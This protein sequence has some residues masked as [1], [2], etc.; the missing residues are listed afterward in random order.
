[1]DFA[2]E[3]II[4]H[5]FRNFDRLSEKNVTKNTLLTLA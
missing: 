3:L 2:K 5:L 1:M 4:L